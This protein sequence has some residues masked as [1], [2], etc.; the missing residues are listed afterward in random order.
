MGG[1]IGK[2]P[3]TNDDEVYFVGIIDCLTSFQLKKKLAFTFKRVLWEPETL[4]TV[5]A[6][7][8]ATRFYNFMTT[9]LLG[10]TN[11]QS[12][13]QSNGHTNVSSSAPVSPEISAKDKK[14]TVKRAQSSKSSSD[15]SSD[16]EE[17]VDEPSGLADY[18]RS[19]K[20]HRMLRKQ[21][22]LNTTIA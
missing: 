21:G 12:Q 11:S 20:S 1:F 5:K 19:C 15:K 8:Y 4:S 16:E 17:S 7:F 10:V 14:D 18:M 9:Q 22:M 13:D 6:K 2:N 3:S